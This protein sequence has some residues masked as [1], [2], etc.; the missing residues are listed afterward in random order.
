MKSDLI[1]SLINSQSNNFFGKRNDPMMNDPYDLDIDIEI[2]SFA[3]REQGGPS[4]ATN[5]NCNSQGTN[6][7]SQCRYC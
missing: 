6:C 4:Y 1:F 3:F 7:I 2:N 5:C